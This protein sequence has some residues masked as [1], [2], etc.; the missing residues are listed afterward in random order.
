MTKETKEEA[1]KRVAWLYLLSRTSAIA[2]KGLQWGI[3]T[4][5]S[6]LSV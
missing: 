4:I 6:A 3:P 1:Q 5:V 2:S